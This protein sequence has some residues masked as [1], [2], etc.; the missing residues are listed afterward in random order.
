MPLEALGED[1]LLRVLVLCDVYTALS[2]AATNKFLR[3]V[4][5]V[6]Q[7]WLSLV[8]DMGFRGMLDLPLTAELEGQSTAQLVDIVKRLVVGPESWGPKSRRSTTLCRRLII[9]SGE[10]AENVVDLLLLRGGR[11]RHMVLVTQENLCLYEIESGRRIWAHPYEGGGSSSHMSVGSST[12]HVLIWS[13]A[14]VITVHEINLKT[15]ESSRVFNHNFTATLDHG[16]H[17]LCDEF[18][19]C[20]YPSASITFLLVNWRE[21][22]YI[23]LSYGPDMYPAAQAML[24]PSHLVVTY[25]H[26]HQQFLAVTALRSLDP[27]WKPLADFTV[28]DLLPIERHPFLA[29][30]PLEYEG[31][32]LCNVDDSLRLF[33]LASPLHQD[34]YEIIVYAD[35][36]QVEPVGAESI[37]PT[38]TT[39]TALLAYRLSAP[40]LPE[41]TRTLHRV[42]AV[43][44]VSVDVCPAFSYAGYCPNPEDSWLPAHAGKDAV[45]DLRRERAGVLSNS[46]RGVLKAEDGWN[47]IRVSANGAVLALSGSSIV[48]SYYK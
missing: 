22:S 1:V 9:E 6:K 15:G 42:F 11:G 14:T 5:L 29:H 10:D 48:I 4:T 13:S 37:S 41:M 18:F 24:I 8:Q 46:T 30:E 21:A 25:A 26:Q 27:Y 44:A 20:P 2:V 47:R 45:I 17:Y 31:K 43:P 38:A 34:A 23:L 39:R 35:E 19:V 40:A 12:I 36:R 7:L 16:R 28:E 3:S 32:P 33:P